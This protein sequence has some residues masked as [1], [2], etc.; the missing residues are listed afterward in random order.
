M[1]FAKA[2]RDPLYARRHSHG[3]FELG[4]I[5]VTQHSPRLRRAAVAR[6]AAAILA[7]D[8]ALGE[9]DDA[10]IITRLGQVDDA[11]M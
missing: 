3:L 5:A 9:F 7:S 1:P 4:D 11:L 10:V 8:P 6:S 2:R